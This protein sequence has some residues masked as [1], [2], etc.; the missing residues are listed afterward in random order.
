[1]ARPRLQPEICCGGDGVLGR[2]EPLAIEEQMIGAIDAAP[3]E[4]SAC[5]QHGDARV[6]APGDARRAFL[7][8]QPVREPHAGFTGMERAA[9]WKQRV[10]DADIRLGRL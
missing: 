2:I 9:V 1:V 10:S 6:A 3:N 4:D 8:S 5:R 7:L